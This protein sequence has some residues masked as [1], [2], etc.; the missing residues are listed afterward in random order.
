MGIIPPSGVKL[1]CIEFTEPFD[2]AVVAT[3]HRLE[4]A[5]PK[6]T[7]LPSMLAGSSP[8]AAKLVIAGGLGP[9][10]DHEGAEKDDRHGGVDRPALPLVAH[11]ASECV[12]QGGRD[13]KDVQHLEEVAERRRVLVGNR[14]VRVPEAAAVG[15]ELLDRDLRGG[16]ALAERLLGA[17][18]RGRVDI[19]TDILRN[20]LPDEDQRADDRTAAAARKAC[21]A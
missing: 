18:E 19:G 6:R 8:S 3:A 15:A 4:L 13:Q 11:H 12:R 17:F 14:G 10:A 21:S 16:R 2:A 1:S 20:A 9:V 7:S 5:M